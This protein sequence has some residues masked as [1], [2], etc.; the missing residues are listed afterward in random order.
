MRRVVRGTLIIN[1]IGIIIVVD[2]GVGRTLNYLG[3]TY[4]LLLLKQVLDTVLFYLLCTT[5]EP[6]VITHIFR[7]FRFSMHLGLQIK[8]LNAPIYVS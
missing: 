4:L 7:S 3:S 2:I 5:T 1:G 6:L 8:G